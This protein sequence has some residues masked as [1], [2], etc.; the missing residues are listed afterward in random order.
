MAAEASRASAGDNLLCA[1]A[2]GPPSLAWPLEAA[3][4]NVRYVLLRAYVLAW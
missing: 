3:R 4:A 1:N 2:S